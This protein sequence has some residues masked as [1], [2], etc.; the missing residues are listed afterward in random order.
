MFIVACFVSLYQYVILVCVNSLCKYYCKYYLC[1]LR[2]YW[3]RAVGHRKAGR[4]TEGTCVTGCQ[5]SFM[6][7]VILEMEPFDAVTKILS[8]EAKLTLQAVVTSK[9]K[10]DKELNSL[11]TDSSVISRLKQHLIRQ[12]EE[13]F[14]VISPHCVATLL[15]PRLE[16]DST[17]MSTEQRAPATEL[18]TQILAQ[19]SERDIPQDE[20]EDSAHVPEKKN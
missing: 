20:S 17:V 3:G 4:R 15:D 6:S 19:V 1:R 11:A 5:K 2:N 16:N 13:Y 18:L 10:L 12:L 7:E 14:K 9:F 8:K